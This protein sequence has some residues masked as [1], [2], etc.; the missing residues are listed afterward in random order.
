MQ[1]AAAPSTRLFL[2]D[3]C[4]QRME[5]ATCVVD[6]VLHRKLQRRQQSHPIGHMQPPM[7]AATTSRNRRITGACLNRKPCVNKSTAPH[8]KK[9]NLIRVL[10]G[11]LICRWRVTLIDGLNRTNQSLVHHLH[12]SLTRS[13][14]EV[15]TS[16][17]LPLTPALAG[18][19][20][21]RTNRQRRFGGMLVLPVVVLCGVSQMREG[22]P[23]E[24]NS[25]LA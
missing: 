12:P 23:S 10:T 6:R 22:S 13:N 2:R 3:G 11:T 17:K 15:P 9:P 4:G 8:S 19:D 24:P 16:A 25:R 18:S 5:C 21:L 7:Y 20:S 14:T 1:C